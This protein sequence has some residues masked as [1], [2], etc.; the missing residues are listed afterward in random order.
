MNHNPEATVIQY[1]DL[2]SQEGPT[3]SKSAV[4]RADGK[5]QSLRFKVK[6][7]KKTQNYIY[8]LTIAT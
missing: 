7:T 4:N 3:Q 6:Q 1:C 2:R 8:L 5:I